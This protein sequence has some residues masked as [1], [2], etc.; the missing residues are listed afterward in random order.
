[1]FILTGSQRESCFLVLIHFAFTMNEVKS[2][3]LGS[4]YCYLSNNLFLINAFRKCI[5][6]HFERAF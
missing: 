6:M 3:L 4:L 2:V 1:M 5:R